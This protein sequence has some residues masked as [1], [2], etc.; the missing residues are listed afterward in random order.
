MH[1]DCSEWALVCENLASLPT[2]DGLYMAHE[3]CPG[4]FEKFNRDHPSML[5]G[6]GFIPNGYAEQGII[7][8]TFDKVKKCW[9]FQS[10]WGWDFAFMAMTLAMLGRRGEAIDML[11]ME[12][13]KNSYVASG[14]N[15]QK[16]RTDLPLYL[17]G[18]GSLLFAVAVM[19]ARRGF[20]QDGLW[21]IEFEGIQPSI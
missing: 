10:M 6:F 14:N 3:N 15:Y 8:K 7:S 5:Y 1:H 21:D 16:G 11:I 12:T 19:L 18:N 9:D 2:C 17:P 4:T 20:P 13:P